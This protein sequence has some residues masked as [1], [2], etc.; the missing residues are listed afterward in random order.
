MGFSG[1]AGLWN[2]LCLRPMTSIH[3]VDISMDLLWLASS[4]LSVR[5]W[6]SCLG[7]GYCGLVER[8]CS[9]Y[10]LWGLFERAPRTC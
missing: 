7:R 3:E 10:L 4:R 1:A 2:Y 6:K 5:K 9:G 8:E